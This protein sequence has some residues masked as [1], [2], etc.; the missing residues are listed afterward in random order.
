MKGQSEEAALVVGVG[1]VQ[2]RLHA[3]L[4]VEG[5]SG[6][7]VPSWMIRSNPFCSTTNSRWVSP[8]GLMA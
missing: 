6:S 7:K 1:R 5:R 2:R 8:G 3:T 4:N